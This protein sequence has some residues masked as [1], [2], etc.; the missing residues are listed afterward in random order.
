MFST[1]ALTF[2]PFLDCSCKDTKWAQE[3]KRC[4][5]AGGKKD[6]AWT[7]DEALMSCTSQNHK[8]ANAK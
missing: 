7:E 8:E 4:L 5:G 1:K 6:S 3:Q 2:L